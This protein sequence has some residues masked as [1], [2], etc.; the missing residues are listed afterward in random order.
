[1]E[2][3]KPRE[4]RYN[5]EDERKM[6]EIDETNEENEKRKI[7]TTIEFLENILWESMTPEYMRFEKK[8]LKA[9]RKRLDLF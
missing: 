4:K 3:K 6:D 5:E 9:T 8:M 2:E 7:M 1:V